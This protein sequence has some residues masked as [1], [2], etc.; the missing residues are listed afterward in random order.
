MD[1][2]D[3]YITLPFFSFFLLFWLMIQALKQDGL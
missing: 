3:D 1:L 2:I